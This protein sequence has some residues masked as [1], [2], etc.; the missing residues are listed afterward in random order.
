M[1]YIILSISLEILG[2][3]NSYYKYIS[4]KY[5]NTWIM[6]WQLNLYRKIYYFQIVTNS[7]ENR[8]IC[9]MRLIIYSECL[10]I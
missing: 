7:E 6:Y 4:P 8:G 2:E 9:F 5:I 3:I 10:P 1:I